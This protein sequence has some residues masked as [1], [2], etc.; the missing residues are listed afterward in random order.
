MEFGKW[1]DYW[2][3][4]EMIEIPNNGQFN[5]Y[6]SIGNHKFCVLCVHGAGHSALSFS[7]LAK[8]IQRFCNVIAYDLKCH[9]ETPGNESDD[10]SIENLTRDCV[11]IYHHYQ[12]PDVKMILLGHSLGG[13]IASK[14]AATLRPTGLFVLDTIEGIAMSMMPKMTRILSSRPQ[15]FSSPK[16]VISYISTSGEMM[17]SKS[18]EIS[19]L[20]RVIEKNGKYVWRTNLFPSERHWN[21][22]FKGFADIFLKAPTYKVIILPSIDRLDKPFTIG[23]MSGKFQLEIVQHSNHCIHEDH[24]QDISTIIERFIERMSEIPQWNFK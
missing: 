20:G 13:C 21:D 11:D 15:Q 22:W 19:A 14:A 2:G 6:T 8:D 12:K 1:S 24:P 7:L 10:L 4:K 23:H 9:G 16:E 17:N 3:A 18:A 5:V